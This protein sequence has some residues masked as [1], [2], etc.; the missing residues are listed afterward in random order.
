MEGKIVLI[1]SS[2]WIGEARAG[3]DPVRELTL[4]A[5]LHDLAICGVVRCEVARGVRSAESLAKLRRFWDVMI[6]VPTDNALWREA[7]DLLWTLDRAGRQIPLPDAVI[8]VSA[9]R[10]GAVVLTHDG[11]FD[12]VA[13]L[14][15]VG[16]LREL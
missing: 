4:A 6:Y 15:T 14:H 13:G 8:A 1:D 16:A 5:H 3:R 7:E 9:L 10:V 11:H 2:W 12:A